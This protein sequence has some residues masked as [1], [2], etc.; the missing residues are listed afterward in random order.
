M[1]QENLSPLAFALWTVLG[2]AGLM[3]IPSTALGAIGFPPA[4]GL[5]PRLLA[6]P[7]LVLAW[8]Y[9]SAA[10]HQ[11]TAFLRATIPAR[12]PGGL[13]LVGLAVLHV[14]PPSLVLLGAIDIASSAW[15][16]RT[17]PPTGRPKPL[18]PAPQDGG[19]RT[20]L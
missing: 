19:R 7:M 20:T 16:W 8:C 2:G 5:W 9:A 13:C 12:A 17:L 15:T 18:A 3:L 14:R 10:A 4:G 1:K 6:L 11:D